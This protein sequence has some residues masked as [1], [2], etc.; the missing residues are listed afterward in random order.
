MQPWKE[1]NPVFA[2]IKRTDK[3]YVMPYGGSGGGKSV[4][5]AQYLIELCFRDSREKVMLVRKH[6]TD[7]GDSN[8]Q[9]VKQVAERTGLDEQLDI[10]RQEK[11]IRFPNG[12]MM[13]GVGLQDRTRLKSFEGPTKI[14]IE[15]ANEIEKSDFTELDR[16]LRGKFKPTFQ[17]FMTFNPNMDRNHW[18]RQDFFD[19][20][21]EYYDDTFRHK[22]TYVDNVFADSEYKKVLDRL[23]EDERNVYK[24]G[25]FIDLD[26]PNQVIK[27]DWI[28][29]AF[30]RD[31]TG[32][33][34][35]PKLG[36]DA[37]RFGD[38]RI[39]FAKV[40]GMVLDDLSSVK[41]QRTTKTASQ[42][43][44]TVERYGI[45]DENVAI[46]T[47]GLGAGV[48]DNLHENGIE[49]NEFKAGSKPVEDD[50]AQES[51]FEFNNK[52]SQAWW[53]LRNL[54]D[55]ENNM[56]LAC[57]ELD[58]GSDAAKRLRNDLTAPRYR[59]KGDKELEV[60]PKQS[61]RSRGTSDWGIKERLG[62]ST[63]EGDSVVQAYFVPRLQRDTDYGR[64]L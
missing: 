48:A 64:V 31:P 49:I 58:E 28:D 56:P 47:V 6:L 22:S 57:F 4:F 13:K 42:T 26:N 23:P 53:Y 39:S 3:R 30:N 43:I 52:R 14:H 55:P 50:I 10:L 24:Y 29:A 25:D 2:P 9:A 27:S 32:S 12:S 34:G 63:D 46:D 8:F 19:P 51:F 54:L 59:I 37:A 11:I 61:G 20:D 16:R 18:I 33:Y 5:I 41:H 7:V 1:Q 35:E 45:A 38:D 21:G 36:V 17:I 44:V 15:E 62:R 60:E 40:D